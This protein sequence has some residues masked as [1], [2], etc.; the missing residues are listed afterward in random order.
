MSLA[1]V[2]HYGIRPNKGIPILNH[3]AGGLHGAIRS[4]NF[5][6]IRLHK[7]KKTHTHITLLYLLPYGRA[8]SYTEPPPSQPS[9]WG[10]FMFPASGESGRET[11][12]R[13]R[14]T[15]LTSPGL[16][17]RASGGGGVGGALGRPAEH[18]RERRKKTTHSTTT[19]SR[20]VAVLTSSRS[21]RV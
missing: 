3:S 7:K 2:L 15:A 8:A 4:S 9:V 11:G 20:R 1:I 5:A 12:L 17:R 21:V 19:H 6:S 16:G 13:L 10:F 18:V 14:H